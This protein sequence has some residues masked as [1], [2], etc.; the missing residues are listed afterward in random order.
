MHSNS[1]SNSSVPGISGLDISN[2]LVC[3][4]CVVKLLVWHVTDLIA[5]S[6]IFLQFVFINSRVN[7]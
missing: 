1:L 2:S 3:C 5:C 7:Y 6:L 4:V